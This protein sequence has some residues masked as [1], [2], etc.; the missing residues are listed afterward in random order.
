MPTRPTLSTAQQLHAAQLAI[1][2][3]LGD[4][5]IKALVAEYGY[6]TSKLNH[7]KALYEA[8]VAAANAQK[9]SLGD[10]KAATA[11]LRQMEAEARDAY[12]ALSRVARATLPEPDLVAL[13]LDG[14][15]PLN[16][17]GFLQAAYTLFDNAGSIGLLAEFGYEADRLATERVKIEALAQ[18]EQAQAL[19]KGSKQQAT[20]DQAAALAALNEWMAQYLKIARVALRNKQQLL[21][22]IGGAAR[23]RRTTTQRTALKK[24]V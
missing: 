19:A 9:A 17:A 10:Q 23:P 6:T 21:E 2:N 16:V 22:K 24:T 12:Q 7:G 11:A 5:E 14:S 20:Q 4:P 15:M 18:A 3:S 13:G 8:A 1:L